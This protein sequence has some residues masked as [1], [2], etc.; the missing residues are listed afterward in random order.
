MVFFLHFDGFPNQFFRVRVLR[1][2]AAVLA[3]FPF[4]GN[5]GA[6]SAPD[7]LLSFLTAVLPEATR[8]ALLAA[9]VTV[10]WLRWLVSSLSL[11]STDAL[12]FLLDGLEG[13]AALSVGDAVIVAF[14]AIPSV[15][16]FFGRPRL[17]F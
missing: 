17:G 14:F 11:G 3:V 15:L 12:R 1:E 16:V 9:G 2:L 7:L 4:F 5:G 10:A 8:L 13:C 6:G